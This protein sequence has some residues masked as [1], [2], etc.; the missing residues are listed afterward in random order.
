MVMVDGIWFPD[1]SHEGG[2]VYA[3]TGGLGKTGHIERFLQA[4]ET[5]DNR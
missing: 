4:I 5:T 3:A 2:G 1:Y